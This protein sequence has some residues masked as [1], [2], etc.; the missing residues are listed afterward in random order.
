MLSYKPT[1]RAG[2][3]RP[4]EEGREF[5]SKTPRHKLEGDRIS[6]V[7]KTLPN[8]LLPL[9]PQD[10][11]GKAVDLNGISD[12][13]KLRLLQSMDDEEDEMGKIGEMLS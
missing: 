4:H 6:R 10:T 5:P 9:I 12:E 11:T 7:D 3:K 2:E 1:K 13:E 8:P